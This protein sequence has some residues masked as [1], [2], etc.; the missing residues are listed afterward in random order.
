[1]GHVYS[2]L[3]TKHRRI[4][5]GT[6]RMVE[7]MQLRADVFLGIAWSQN[8]FIYEYRVLCAFGEPNA[9]D[10]RFAV[11]LEHGI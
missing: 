11:E 7:S 2:C 5:S 4:T 9:I 6:D 8:S 3:A 10:Q 1:M